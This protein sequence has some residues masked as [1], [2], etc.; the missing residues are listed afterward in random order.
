M[1]AASRHEHACYRASPGRSPVAV[2]FQSV[3]HGPPLGNS[4]SRCSSSP[5]AASGTLR[6]LWVRVFGGRSKPRPDFR[7]QLAATRRVAPLLA[8]QKP[9][10]RLPFGDDV[11][12]KVVKQP[13][14]T[15]PAGSRGAEQRLVPGIIASI[16]YGFH[17]T[18]L[19]CWAGVTTRGTANLSSP[20]AKSRRLCVTR[21]STPPAIAS[22]KTWSSSASGKLGRQR[23]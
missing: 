19:K 4:I 18:V 3:A 12:H 21:C 17:L 16:G 6:G 5:P 8:E 13:L 20:R 10:F 1:P 23:K 9:R 7:Q 11:R 14:H 22:S 2:P 15:C